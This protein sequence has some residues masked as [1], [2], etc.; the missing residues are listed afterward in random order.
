MLGQQLPK[1]SIHMIYNETIQG[2][3]E[4]VLKDAIAYLQALETRVQELSNGI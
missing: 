1:D 3:R 4:Q 2:R